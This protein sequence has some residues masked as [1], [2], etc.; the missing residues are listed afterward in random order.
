VVQELLRHATL[1]VTTDTYL[2][3]LSPDKREAQT[4]L[5]RLVLRRKATA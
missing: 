2:Q 4:N 1:K 5:V 3:A